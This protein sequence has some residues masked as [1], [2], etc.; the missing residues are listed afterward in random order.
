MTEAAG[1]AEIDANVIYTIG[2]GMTSRLLGA[3]FLPGTRHYPIS[4]P[5]AGNDAYY[6]ETQY[7]F[8]F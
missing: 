8:T 2:R 5:G 1:P 6:V 4:M 7:T 3:T